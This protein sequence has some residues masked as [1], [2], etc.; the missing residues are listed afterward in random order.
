MAS[1]DTYQAGVATMG[2]IYSDGDAAYVRCSCTNQNR[3]PP[4]SSHRLLGLKHCNACGVIS[5]WWQSA[6]LMLPGL[7]PGYAQSNIASKLHL[8]TIHQYHEF[9]HND[10]GFISR[11]P[12]H[13]DERD[14]EGINRQCT[15]MARSR[16]FVR[17][18]PIVWILMHDSDGGA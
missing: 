11:P 2:S 10:A 12:H 4:P 14:G 3:C 16:Q 6:W 17:G 8:L 5:V 15:H 18:E 1:L 9:R 7:K 13:S